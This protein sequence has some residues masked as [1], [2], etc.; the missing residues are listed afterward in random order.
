[1]KKWLL[2]IVSSFA[3][4][5]AFAEAPI[6]EA[7]VKA[8]TAYLYSDGVW[9][10]TFDKFYDEFRKWGR[11]ELTQDKSKADIVVALTTKEATDSYAIGIIGSPGGTMTGGS[12]SR[13]YMH[14][15]TPDGKTIL[16][17]DMAPETFLLSNAGK[18]LVKNLK[19]R[20]KEQ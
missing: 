20:M 14:V 4:P 3:L 1:M 2:L 16:W 15:M 13:F 19:K 6:P 11:F 9:Y 5:F 7:L 12:S 8:K 10:K 18:D 17:S